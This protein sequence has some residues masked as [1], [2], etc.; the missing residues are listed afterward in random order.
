MAMTLGKKEQ[1]K[2]MIE[3]HP[4]DRDVVCTKLRSWNE[5]HPGNVLCTKLIGECAQKIKPDEVSQIRDM[6]KKIAHTL[7]KE[8]GGRFLKI[9]DEKHPPFCMIMNEKACVDRVNRALRTSYQK[10]ENTK[11]IENGEAPKW[12]LKRKRPQAPILNLYEAVKGDKPIDPHAMELIALVCN[13]RDYR[14]L[15]H[16]FDGKGKTEPEKERLMRL[17]IRQRYVAA[18]AAGMSTLEFSEKLMNFWG[19]KIVE[20]EKETIAT[21]NP[22]SPKKKV[23]E[24]PQAE[25]TQEGPSI[26]VPV[27][28]DSNTSS[29]AKADTSPSDLVV[30]SN[31][32]STIEDVMD[33]TI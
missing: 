31:A 3:F 9:P 16:P 32:N 20:R 26:S 1:D 33:E 17:Q 5:R 19:G 22:S 7:T 4:T 14:V 30:V 6:A 11:A 24:T 8:L 21:Q 29:E 23:L 15:D 18:K 25:S 10:L 2:N 12:K 28:Q 27:S 13:H